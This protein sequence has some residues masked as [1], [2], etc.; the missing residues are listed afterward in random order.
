[1]LKK[2]VAMMGEIKDTSTAEQVKAAA[3]FSASFYCEGTKKLG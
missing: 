1:M 2:V 3:K